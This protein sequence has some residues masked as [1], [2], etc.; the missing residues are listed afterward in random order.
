MA[1]AL[2]LRRRRVDTKENYAVHVNL[3]VFKF[4]RKKNLLN[5]STFSDNSF[6]IDSI[7][8]SEKS[9]RRENGRALC[10]R[11]NTKCLFGEKNVAISVLK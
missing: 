7:L 5:S 10:R 9:G 2:D 11:E 1:M 8:N 4:I 6:R 3:D